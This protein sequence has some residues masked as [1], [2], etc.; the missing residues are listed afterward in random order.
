MLVTKLRNIFKINRN[1]K[2]N[3]LIVVIGIF[4][5]VSLITVTLFSSMM[6]QIK[7]TGGNRLGVSAQATSDSGIDIAA[8]W[9]AGT[10]LTTGNREAPRKYQ[11]ILEGSLPTTQ[12][13]IIQ[14]GDFDVELN[15]KYR[16]I[17]ESGQTNIVETFTDADVPIALVVD[18]YATP[19]IENSLS[20]TLTDRRTTAEISF[21]YPDSSFNKAIFSGSDSEVV[22]TN[23]MK[24]LESGDPTR[25]VD[26]HVYANGPIVCNTQTD[27]N[28]R[29]YSQGSITL[30]NKCKTLETLWAG[31]NVSLDSGNRIDGD[32]FAVGG[33][34]MKNHPNVQGSIIA[35]D[36]IQLGGG[37]DTSNIDILAPT[38]DNVNN[39]KTVRKN[40]C[41]T[42]S[43]KT[44]Y[45]HV[46]RDV[47]SING[48]VLAGNNLSSVGGSVFAGGDIDFNRR[49]NPYRGPSGDGVGNPVSDTL[50]IR[51]DATA[52]GNVNST[53]WI[54]GNVRAGGQVLGTSN[55]NSYALNKKIS[56]S[57][58][59]TVLSAP[60]SGLQTCS[61]APNNNEM[62]NF[63]ENIKAH[64][65]SGTLPKN[66][67]EEVS[68]KIRVASPP[69]E[70]MPVINAPVVEP[71][72]DGPHDPWV[73][74][75]KVNVTCNNNPNVAGGIAHYLKN[76]GGEPGVNTVVMVEGC[77]N[78]GVELNNAE[79]NVNENMAVMSPNGFNLANDTKIKTSK[80][81]LDLLLIVPANLTSW[82]GEGNPPGNGNKPNGG[83][84]NR[85]K[86]DID[87]NKLF[88][89]NNKEET[90]VSLMLYTPYRV[91]IKNQWNSE[92]KGVGNEGIFEGQIYAG[93]VVIP[94]NSILKMNPVA[95]PSEPQTPSPT[96]D[97]TSVITG[98]F[99]VPIDR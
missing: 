46:C 27:I 45:A 18:S 12:G 29:I 8:A 84:K 39:I 68:G 51:G 34:I 56:G 96:D 53:P 69:K 44:V 37:K 72:E 14:V 31:G 90:K 71:T 60:V 77:G 6:A 55:W 95:I 93:T 5:V 24:L 7:F 11:E 83:W 64:N 43:P 82:N 3:G 42:I 19:T 15:Y 30:E 35:N 65:A 78:N 1:E 76:K 17:N 54:N 98:R 67:I 94:Q 58:C 89:Y 62:K 32:V 36:S 33:V 63:Y 80:A 91:H 49:A 86:G 97:I 20:R 26:A 21:I 99:N 92:V 75:A 47:L 85:V 81:G 13:E 59:A 38:V 73:S 16:V 88:F 57:S 10:D 28:G 87:I 23:G 4:G 22:I 48:S 74:W 50:F 25:G 61:A 66:L 79:I 9:L 40:E 41:F 2:G 52:I 70:T